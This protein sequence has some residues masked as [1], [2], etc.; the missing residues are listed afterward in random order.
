MNPTFIIPLTQIPSIAPVDSV[1]SAKS[2]GIFGALSGEDAE[3]SFL[4][5]LTEKIQGVKDLETQSLQSAY[6]V[7]MGYSDDLE[8]AMIDSSKAS[9]A[10]QMTTQLTTRAVNA[11]KEILEMQI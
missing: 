4:N 11:Y 10:I 1:T 7:S 8:S 2:N 5:L 3:S 9:S 6:D